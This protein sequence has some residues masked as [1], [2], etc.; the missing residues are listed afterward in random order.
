MT[1]GTR[2]TDDQKDHLRELLQE[3]QRYIAW[4]LA[5]SD[6]HDD[7]EKQELEERQL[8]SYSITIV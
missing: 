5:N 4:V 8:L 3:D 2:L 6:Y 1:H 7:E